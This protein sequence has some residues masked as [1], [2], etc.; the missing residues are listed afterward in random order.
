[1][2]GPTHSEA[3]CVSLR[4]LGGNAKADSIRAEIVRRWGPAEWLREGG[5]GFDL[6]LFRDNGRLWVRIAPGLY[7]VTEEGKAHAAA[8]LGTSGPTLDKEW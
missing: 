2:T 7:E 3:I 1:M 8:F 4:K 6:A 5:P